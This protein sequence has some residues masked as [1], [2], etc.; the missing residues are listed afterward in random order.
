MKLKYKKS[1]KR[2]NTV[3]SAAFSSSS[4]E[5]FDAM[6]SSSQSQSVDYEDKNRVNDS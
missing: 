1:N 2:L 3:I 6:A 5:R 4:Q